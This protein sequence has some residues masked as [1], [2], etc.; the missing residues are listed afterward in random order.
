MK[1]I[2]IVDDHEENLYLLR[3]LLEGNGYEVQ[4]AANGSEA[5][6][7]AQEGKQDLIISDILMP[8]M[9]GFALCRALKA[10][11][12]LKHVPL[13]FYTATYR[14]AKDE[15]LA[16]DMG[17]NA[18]IVKPSEPD[19]FM[20]RVEQILAANHEG[21]LNASQKQTAG[22][23]IILKEYNEVLINKLEQKMLSL[24]QANKALE[25][26]ITARKQVEEALR[27]S[28]LITENIP[29]GLYIYHLEDISDDRTLRMVYANPAVK[30]LT[31]VGPED[32]IGKTLDENFPGLRAQGI[33]QRYA[34]VVRNQAARTFEDVTYGDDRVPLASFAVK[35]FP[36]PGNSVGIAFENIT[37]RKRAEVAL[38][39]S[40]GRFRHFFEASY[41]GKSMTL[42]DGHINV[43]RALS[44]MLGYS[45]EELA[46]KTWQD[47]TPSADI[48][49]IWR[50]IKPELVNENET[51]PATIYC[52]AG[53]LFGNAGLL[54]HTAGGRAAGCGIFPLNRFGWIS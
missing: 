51:P 22:D 3:V 32:V 5:L 45:V 42:P 2:L 26:E 12:R 41:V 18:F 7:K 36:L 15:K 10:D 54:I 27:K 25:A 30:D 43:N 4:Q 31:G 19:E 14:D 6:A 53:S 28:Q 24:E 29:T 16:L 38:R 50:T 48:E 46:G 23:E 9:D 39:E 37:E 11:E 33:P 17:A 44:D 13:I 8:V 40:E 49:M 34:K 35:A 1:R 52:S 21:K 20:R 47:I